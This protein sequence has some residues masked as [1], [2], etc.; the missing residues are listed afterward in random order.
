M[1]RASALT[2]RSISSSVIASEQAPSPRWVRRMP[3]F[4]SP[5]KWRI[6]AS[7]AFGRLER[8]SMSGSAGRP[9]AVDLADRRQM[10]P[11]AD[12]LLP[13]A[14]PDPERDDLVEDQHDAVALGEAAQVP[15]EPVEGRDHAADPEKRIHEDRG[16]V[17]RLG[18]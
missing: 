7:G 13:P 14:P 10:G 11:A 2:N 3:S 15:K 12:P 4:S 1:T 8:E 17:L 18:L 16:Q 6:G 5:M 9:A